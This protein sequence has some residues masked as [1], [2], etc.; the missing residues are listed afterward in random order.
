MRKK[1]NKHKKSKMEM[2]L[3]AVFSVLVMSKEQN[4]RSK[5][6][7]CKYLAIRA[8]TFTTAF[9][10][11]DQSKFQAFTNLGKS[12]VLKAEINRIHTL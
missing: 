11:C 1:V 7:F 2:V 5:I 8:P 4:R 3:V 6:F 12:Q 9:I 10:S